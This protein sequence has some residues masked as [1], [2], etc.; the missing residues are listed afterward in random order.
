MENPIA[1][2]KLNDFIFCPASIYFHLIDEDTNTLMYQNHYQINGKNAHKSI[3]NHTYSDLKNVLQGIDVYSSKYN[4]TGKIDIYFVDKKLL[5]ER[6]KKISKIYDGYIFQIYGEFFGLTEMGYS[7]KE[8]RLYSM[9]DNI[10][11]P[12][13]LPSEDLIM[14]KK[15]EILISEIQN[16]NLSNFT[17]S[18]NAKCEKCIYF[19][20]C[21][22]HLDKNND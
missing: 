10:N 4:L 15:F 2:S 19:D 14:T 1:I 18:N 3:D 16:F 12:I 7:I 8:L 13:P 6:K 5:V 11:Y 9:D 20:L 17:Q 21:T 22:F